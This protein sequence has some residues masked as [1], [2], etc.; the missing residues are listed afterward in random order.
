[1]DNFSAAASRAFIDARR[2]LRKNI[3]RRK[4]FIEMLYLHRDG[5]KFNGP[6]HGIMEYANALDIT[7]ALDDTNIILQMPTGHHVDLC[8]D[9]LSH[10]KHVLRETCR[11]KL[12]KQLNE[13]TREEASEQPSFKKDAKT[14]KDMYGITAFVDT[15]ATLAMVSCKSKEKYDEQIGEN[16]LELSQINEHYVADKKLARPCKLTNQSR[17]RLQTIIAGSIRPPH[18]LVHTGRTE[19][20]QCCHPA[21]KGAKCDTHHVFWKCP[22]FDKVRQPY[23]DCIERKL[24]NIGRKS[25][26]R[27]KAIRKIINTPC[28]QQCG[29][30]PADQELL[31]KAANIVVHSPH[32]GVVSEDQYF[33]GDD[34]A[35]TINAGGTRYTKIYTDGSC[36]E[37]NMRDVARA[38]WGVY[39]APN[40]PHNFAAPLNGPVQTSYRA[41][42]KAVLHVLRHTTTPTMVMCDCQ[43]VVNT[44][45]AY[46]E[47]GTMPNNLQEQDVWDDIF[48]L[49]KDLSS[50]HFCI[51]W[52]P[53]H[54]D[55]EANLKKRER[56]LE[57]GAGTMQDIE[58]NVEADKLAFQGADAHAKITETI[59]Q[60]QD[61]Y[62]FTILVQ[63]MLLE[64]WENFIQTDSDCA[65]ADLQDIEELEK[66]MLNAQF[67]AQLDDDYNPFDDDEP[68]HDLCISQTN[69]TKTDNKTDCT[70]TIHE[71][72]SVADDNKQDQTNFKRF[73]NYGWRHVNDKIDEALQ[74][75]VPDVNGFNGL[76]KVPVRSVCTYEKNVNG[77]M[78]SKVFEKYHIPINWW[79]PLA[80]WLRDTVWSEYG[81][82]DR[83]DGLA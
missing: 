55:E 28:F 77:E 74:L 9:H 63:K 37:G 27:V 22:R 61:K 39:Y 17:R 26:S 81:L 30:C 47:D 34:N 51:Q 57:E 8:T 79:E 20:N 46:L 25:D 19:S 60:M 5:S 7:V 76:N 50:K 16:G 72:A 40:S 67:E 24:T 64:I 65:E 1:V 12:M 31:A 66:M 73:P 29:I 54:L 53:G 59:I 13:R 23:L 3:D 80:S 33:M 44:L 45:T 10:L 71:E 83:R 58:G 68:A 35:Q 4:Q 21:C 78:K 32:V 49:A 82:C 56:F 70:D 48:Y 75:D 62:D 41:E 36:R 18:R 15:R 38:G 6:A 43:A 52:M 42:L 11:Y 14:R 69:G 2:T